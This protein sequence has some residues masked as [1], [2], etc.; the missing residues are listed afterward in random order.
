TRA[1]Q[2]PHTEA[3]KRFVARG[4][5]KHERHY[6]DG[7]YQ[8]RQGDYSTLRQGRLPKDIWSISNNCSEGR[9]VNAFARECG[10]PPHAAK[11]PKELAR[12]VVTLLS[13]HG[14]L[15]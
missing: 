5:V 9:L 2:E 11:M 4:G 8:L 12:R 14:G 15:V 3:H 13:R 6:G 10:L 1:L 7:A